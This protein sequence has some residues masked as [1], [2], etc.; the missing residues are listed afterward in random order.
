MG[1]VWVQGEC[2][3]SMGEREGACGDKWSGWDGLG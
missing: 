2:R 1:G 3:G